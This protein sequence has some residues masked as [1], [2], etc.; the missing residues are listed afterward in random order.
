MKQPTRIF[1]LVL[2]SLMLQSGVGSPATGAPSPIVPS[3]EDAVAIRP[4]RQE[5]P[6]VPSS[7]LPGQP[8]PTGTQP[9]ADGTVIGGSAE[10]RDLVTRAL[11]RYAT[12]GLELPPLQFELHEDTAPC[13]G[14]RGFFSPSS[15]PWT[16]GLCTAEE[17]PIL[18]EIGHAW[19]QYGLSDGER[20]AYVEHQG[21]VS[22]N[23]SETRWRDRGS[24]DAANT[25][26]WGLLATPLRNM[27]S[28]GPLAEKAEA[29]RLLTG[30]DPP[31]IE[32]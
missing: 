14:N 28:E 24:E 26:A 31:R 27:P 22:W 8:T 29:F 6:A 16:I 11:Q 10:Q 25:L 7:S 18:H 23:D 19:A 20:A 5:V 4:T 17:L 9:P 13:G 12:S 21:L 3:T 1:L 15:E 2:S 30:L 32:G